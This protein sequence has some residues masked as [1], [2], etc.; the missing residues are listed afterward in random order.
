MLF[1]CRALSFLT[2]GI[3]LGG[4]SGGLTPA[5]SSPPESAAQPL[6]VAEPRTAGSRAATAANATTPVKHVVVIDQENR[7]FDDL[8]HG[9]PGANTAVYGNGHDG[10]R[11]PLVQVSLAASWD[12]IH[13][14]DQFLEDYDGGAMD[15]FDE[16]IVRYRS[17]CRDPHNKPT[18]WLL[19]DM[20][21]ESTPTAYGFVPPSEIKPYWMMAENY[22]LGDQMFASNNGPSYPSHQ[23]MIA[24]QAATVVENPHGG[25]WGCDASLSTTT[26]MLA[27]GTT[28]PPFFPPATGIELPG[29]A[30]CFEYPTMATLLDNSGITWSYYATA[31][32]TRSYR[33]S[34]FDAIEPV[35]YSELWD[36]NVKSPETR[37]LSDI[38]TGRLPQ[39]A[40]VTPSYENSDHAGSRSLSGPDWVASIVNAIG[41]SPYWSSTA[42]IIFWDDWGGWYDHVAPPQYPNPLTGAYE[43]LG[44]RVPLIVVSPYAKRHYV[45]HEQH[46]IASS[47]H[48]I[49]SVFGLPSLGTAD[50]RADALSDM[51]DFSQPAQKFQAIPTR[52]HASDFLNQQPSLVPPD[53]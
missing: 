38:A 19:R 25:L 9:F 36:T 29:P 39:V 23:Y 10:A 42:I 43:G 30:P 18:C 16:E 21:S 26:L 47:L 49:E 31:L 45:S 20:T 3:V 53:D 44:F 24:G 50:A 34:A 37:I 35:R 1:S 12:L 14:H 40:W 17:R 2:V 6:P 52:L 15:G 4:C 7:S 46:E 13:T 8:F 27:Y 28:Q 41:Q 22:A 32:G 51:F 33:W 5:Y 11:Y 48:F